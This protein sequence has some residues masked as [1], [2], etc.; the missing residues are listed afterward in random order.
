MGFS[1]SAGRMVITD[2]SGNTRFDSDEKLFVITD[3]I[4]GSVTASAFTATASNVDLTTVNSQTDRTLSSCN[5]YADTIRGAFRMSTS[6]ARGISISGWFNASG[7]YVHMWEGGGGVISAFTANVRLS[8]VSAY[9]FFCS[10]G[11]VYLR[12]RCRMTSNFSGSSSTVITTS[13]AAPTFEYKLFAGT[14]V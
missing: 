3:F 8:R 1:A 13:V 10:G 7:T 6:D 9:T 5:A 14:F 2:G 11:G 12:E 4:S